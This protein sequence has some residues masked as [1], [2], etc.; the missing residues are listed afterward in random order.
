MRFLSLV[1]IFHVISNV[2]KMVPPISVSNTATSEKLMVLTPFLP[3]SVRGVATSQ[4]KCL[5]R[6]LGR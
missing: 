6:R 1:A 3:V 4:E 5:T 2:T